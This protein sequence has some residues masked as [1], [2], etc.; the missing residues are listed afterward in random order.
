MTLIKK[1]VLDA[2]LKAIKRNYSWLADEITY[3][4]SYMSQVVNNRCKISQ[5]FVGAILRRTGFKYEDLFFDDGLIDTRERYSEVYSVD[6]DHMRLPKYK[7]RLNEIKRNQ[8]G[9][10]EKEFA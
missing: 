4:K 2:Y 1:E 8:P 6:G 9:Y 7:E 5:M 3:D 10:A